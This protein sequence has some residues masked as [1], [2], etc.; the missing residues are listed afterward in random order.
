MGKLQGV[1]DTLY[2]P[3][4][5]RIYA[6]KKIPEFFYDEK[7]LE[8][9]KELPDHSVEENANEYMHIASV[10]RFAIFD[11][12]IRE[13][14]AAH[15][16]CNIVNL[17]CGLETCYYRIQDLR[18]TFYELDLPEV[19]AIRRNVLGESEKEVL[20]SGSLFDVEWTK[21]VNTKLPTLM[22]VAGV[23]QYFHTEE[24]EA[25]LKQVKE[26]FE[27]AEIVFDA[28]SGKDL[29]GANKMVQK[30]G[31]VDA[32]MYFS[33][34]DSA[35]FAK[36]NNIILRK[37]YPFFTQARKALKGKVGLYTRIAMWVVDTGNM[38]KVLHFKLNQ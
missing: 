15:G 32:M 29:K 5:A 8:L 6:S 31:N 33:I 12:V 2:I 9:E 20:L 27:D 10:A 37:E 14:I 21:Q 4:T 1:K 30:T 28:A 11:T 26:I 36:K 13:F 22:V 38:G 23:F 18:A 25:F 17:G 35:A 3:L 34:D 19:I 7:A 16:I 24:V